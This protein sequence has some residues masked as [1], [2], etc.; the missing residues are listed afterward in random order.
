[1]K[2]SDAIKLITLFHI[3]SSLNTLEEVMADTYYHE[4]PV[5]D[6]EVCALLDA[7]YASVKD[8]N[9]MIQDYIASTG[10][11]DTFTNAIEGKYED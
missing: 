6:D 9:K 2:D 4:Y 3:G 10:L 7:V 11:D 1:M 5:F 8:S